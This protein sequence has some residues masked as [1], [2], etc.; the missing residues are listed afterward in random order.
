MQDKGWSAALGKLSLKTK[1][2]I[3]VILLSCVGVWLAKEMDLVSFTKWVAS[4]PS[5][6][7]RERDRVFRSFYE[8]VELEQR[9]SP[10][11]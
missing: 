8:G 4:K 3:G 9:V 11:L 5:V 10:V 2:C 1:V 6:E 7:E